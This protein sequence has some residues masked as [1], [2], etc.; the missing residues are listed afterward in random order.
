M[1]LERKVRENMRG[2]YTI[3]FHL[4]AGW[5][6]NNSRTAKNNSDEFVR[7]FAPSTQVA[8]RQSMCLFETENL[9]WE[10][11]MKAEAD[12]LILWREECANGTA[13]H[14]ARM[15]RREGRPWCEY[16]AYLLEI[17]RN[18]ARVKGEI[19]RVPWW[20]KFIYGGLW[21]IKST[22]E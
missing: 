19:V 4:Q 15:E 3:S 12:E 5:D 13:W 10:R 6:S 22:S 8:S 17:E 16:D 20:D 1:G 9:W 2:V 21:D 11:L 14:K 18:S 7:K